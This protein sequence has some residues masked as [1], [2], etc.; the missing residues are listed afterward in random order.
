MRRAARGV[1][2]PGGV[3]IYTARELCQ[4]DDQRFLAR[5]SDTIFPGFLVI[6]ATSGELRMR[7]ACEQPDSSDRAQAEAQF[8]VLLGVLRTWR[9][10][11]GEL[12][13]EQDR[14]LGGVARDANC[15]QY[16]SVGPAIAYRVHGTE[17]DDFVGLA[18][19]AL[20][21]DPQLRA[22]LALFGQP[23]LTTR[24]LYLVYEH[25]EH[26]FGSPKA[27]AEATC[28]S[29]K[30]RDR[31]TQSANNLAPE[32]GGRHIGQNRRIPLDLDQQRNW[33]RDLLLRWIRVSN[34]LGPDAPPPS[35]PA[36]YW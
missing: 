15:N 23:H 1:R 12:R 35:G 13:V 8:D 29:G 9:A 16:V 34:D 3:A 14:R 36:S 21:V 27:I 26:S 20:L 31:F 19:R 30:S 5:L 17:L 7:S 24:E 2:D 18:A 6:D 10:A 28:I 22:A 11:A 33:I 4:H 32:S 25:A